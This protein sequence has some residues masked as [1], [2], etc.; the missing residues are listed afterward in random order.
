M[1]VNQDIILHFPVL[2]QS[3][4]PIIV[5]FFW[6][7]LTLFLPILLQLAS[8]TEWNAPSISPYTA[9]QLASIPK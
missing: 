4:A 9:A 5:I 8:T 1:E 7:R 2:I 6:F 3:A